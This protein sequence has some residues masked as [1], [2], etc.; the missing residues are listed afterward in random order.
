MFISLVLAN[1]AWIAA[2]APSAEAQISNFVRAPKRPDAIVSV[3]EL[4]IPSRA[5]EEFQ[6]GLRRLEKRDP[7]G[8]LEHFDAAISSSPDYYEAYY[9]RGVAE[10]QMDKNEEALQSFQ[11]AID[12]SDGRYARA[13]FGYGLIL[14]RQGK[15]EEAERIVRQGLE[16]EPNLPDG[17]VVLGFLLLKLKR[18]DEAEN[19]AREALRLNDPNAAKGYLVLA[20]VDAERRDYQAQVRDLNEYLKLRPNDPK[21]EFLRAARDVAKKLANRAAAKPETARSSTAVRSN[22]T[23]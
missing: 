11:K 18:T 7:A 16:T 2:W 15:P 9:H 8:S 20:D 23:N 5:R 10:M 6:R 12:L 21:K 14:C 22:P 17:H 4:Q 13:Q 1:S 19:S 3:R